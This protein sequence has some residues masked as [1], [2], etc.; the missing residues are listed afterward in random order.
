MNKLL[1]TLI[2][3]NSFRPELQSAYR[4]YRSTETATTKVMSDVYEAADA[5]SV[6]LLGLLDLSAAFDTVD[7]R[8]LLERLMHDYGVKGLAIQ[9]IE[10]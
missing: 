1:A 2:D 5:G 3:F 4:K 10:S 6:T 9:W 8:I 7:H